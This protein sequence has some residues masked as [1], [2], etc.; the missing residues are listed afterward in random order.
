MKTIK[1]KIFFKNAKG[2]EITKI[3]IYLNKSEYKRLR[4]KYKSSGYRHQG[5][6]KK[7][8]FER[9]TLLNRVFVLRLISILINFKSK[10][11]VSDDEFNDVFEELKIIKELEV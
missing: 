9:Y 3:T 7:L 4:A 10:N 11:V 2:E 5:F 1:D 8:L 6:L